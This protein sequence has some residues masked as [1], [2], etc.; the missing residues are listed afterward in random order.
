MSHSDA[1]NVMPVN[2]LKSHQDNRTRF[3]GKQTP[4]P[5]TDLRRK[6]RLRNHL[7][8][9]SVTSHIIITNCAQ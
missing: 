5:E 2:A 1:V 9:S 8:I 4:V 6:A 7:V 3:H